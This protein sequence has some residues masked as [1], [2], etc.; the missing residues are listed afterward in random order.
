[1][2]ARRSGHTVGAPG[3]A[4]DGGAADGGKTV[5]RSDAAVAHCGEAGGAATGRVA[6]W[7]LGVR[8]RHATAREPLLRAG[9]E[10]AAIA[11]AG[12]VAVTEAAVIRRR[13][14]GGTHA[15]GGRAVGPQRGKR[16]EVTTAMAASV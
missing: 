14:R 11:E 1:M 7:M 3:G 10:D 12:G 4:T 9:G 6:V 5:A 15:E 16:R 2:H 8:L 13:E